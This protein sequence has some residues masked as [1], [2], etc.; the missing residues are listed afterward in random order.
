MN[1]AHGF[2]SRGF[3]FQPLPLLEERKK[4]DGGAGAKRTGKDYTK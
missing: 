4:E 1:P 3:R 2:Q